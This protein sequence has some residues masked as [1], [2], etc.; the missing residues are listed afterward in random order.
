MIWIHTKALAEPTEEFNV[1]LS[2]CSDGIVLKCFYK[3]ILS[4]TRVVVV[5][6]RKFVHE[7]MEEGTSQLLMFRQTK[8]VC[9]T[10]LTSKIEEQSL[11]YS[12]IK[13]QYK[14]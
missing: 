9:L 6:D 13:F 4:L 5:A 1:D 2:N 7:R 14:L 8:R 10:S 3:Y 11:R 12:D